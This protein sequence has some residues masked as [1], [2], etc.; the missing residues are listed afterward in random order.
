MPGPGRPFKK[1]DPRPPGAGRKAEVD[2]ADVRELAAKWTEEAIERLVYWMK[3]DNAKASAMAAQILLNRGWGTP[4]Q[5]I[6]AK[7][8]HEDLRGPDHDALASKLE[9]ALL[10]RALGKA[11]RP[12]VQ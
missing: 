5:T 6:L 8:Q 2:I 7:V 11:T 4:A 12:T 1:G 9:K 3:S 10:G